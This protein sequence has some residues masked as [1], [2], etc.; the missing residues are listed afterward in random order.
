MD[1]IL[2]V[3]V[4]AGVAIA[5][6][7]AVSFFGAKRS[8][9]KEQKAI[10]DHRRT[11]ERG[12]LPPSLYPKVDLDVCIGSGT[13]VE[14][15][16]EKDVLGLIDG[17]A[18]LVNPT[19]CIGHGECLRACPVNAIQLVLGSE[20]RGVDIPLLE[21]DFQTNV[22]GLYVVGELGGMGLIYNAM[23]QALQCMES[24]RQRN[25]QKQDGVHQVAI[26]G[27]G[28]AGMAAAC[29][30]VHDGLDYVCLDQETLAGT[31]L[32]YPRHKL[33]MTRP[34]SLPGYGQ[35][36]VETIAKESLLEIWED[37]VKK[38]GIRVRT[39]T[40][41]D[42]VKKDGGLFELT[43]G[44]EKI[45][46]QTVVLA[47]GRRG[48]PKKLG[49]PGE[50]LGKVSYRLLE[51][52]NYRGAKVL[53]VGGGDSAVEAAIALDEIGAIVHL[54][55]RGKIFDRIRPK[56]QERLDGAGG[57]HVLLEAQVKEIR[58]KVAIV[59]SGGVLQ[60]LANDYVIVLI[61][62]VL[63]SQFLEHAGVEVRTFKGE[64][65]APANR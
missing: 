9:E 6:I 45:L 38:T 13:C 12:A 54:V 42:A 23:T 55:H 16:P 60:E 26:I 18:R 46:A 57:V 8:G 49:V 2:M 5:A 3:L 61:G 48:S 58:E 22:D 41:V 40:K 59:E 28:P 53:V 44:S 47:M 10:E 14:V 17:K 32:H 62:G 50:A 64:A 24:I 4:G 1:P 19:S 51:P 65:F 21:R 35:V 34:V 33:V 52:E 37:I 30:A 56:N 27:A 39:E 43:I 20:M 63:P 25:L 7:V 36:K 15:C 11:T 29:A 31:V